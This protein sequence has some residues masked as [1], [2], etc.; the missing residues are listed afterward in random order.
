MLFL[1]NHS[2][3]RR[4][5]LRASITHAM[6]FVFM[7]SLLVPH[8]APAVAGLDASSPAFMVS[9]NGAGTQPGEPVE[10]DLVKHASCA[11]H[12]FLPAQSLSTMLVRKDFE[13]GYIALTDT[14]P[15]RGPPSLP[16]KPPRA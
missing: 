13:R 14:Q 9:T 2:A 11:C 3:K 6:A 4:R 16:F 7:F 10:Y 5:L 12:I 8:P 15:P 1:A